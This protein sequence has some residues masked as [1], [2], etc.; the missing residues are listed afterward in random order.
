MGKHNENSKRV[1]VLGAGWYG[2]HIALKAAAAGHDV[3]IFDKEPDIFY[4][5]SGAFGIRLHEGPHYPRSK[6]TRE[7]CQRGFDEFKITYPELV[8]ENSHSIYARG[9]FDAEGKPSKVDDDTFRAVCNERP[10]CREISPPAWGLRDVTAAYNL[11]EPS[12]AVGPKLRETFRAYLKS[13]NVAVQTG[14]EVRSLKK[15]KTGITINDDL[16]FDVVVNATS[17]QAFTPISSAL[18]FDIEVI[19]QPCTALIYEDTLSSQTKQPPFSFIVMDGW[20][21]C[22]MPYED[23]LSDDNPRGPRNYIVT[24]GSYTILGSCKTPQE[25]NAILNSVDKEHPDFISDYVKPGCEKEMRRFWPEFGRRFKY[26]G[27]QGR[28]VAKIKSETEYR[29]AVTFEKDGIIHIIPGKVSNVFDAQRETNQLI[30]GKDVVKRGDISYASG[31]E[32]DRSLHEMVE[33]PKDKTRNTGELQTFDKW[34]ARKAA[35]SG[36]LACCLYNPASSGNT[37]QQELITPEQIRKSFISNKPS[38]L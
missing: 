4:G 32:L 18:P 21:P 17:Y 27:W 24:H 1:A 15:H 3:V 6:G 7:S 34:K 26:L 20:F 36:K 9:T 19:Y 31:G 37:P 38:K 13:A 29:S 2:S 12:I 22:I 8:V 11:P 33:K 35:A 25:A 10:G 28:V 23:G 16:N 5:L 30:E 14:F